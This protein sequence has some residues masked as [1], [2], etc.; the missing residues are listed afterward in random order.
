MD[1]IAETNRIKDRLRE[2][3][4]AEQIDDV[5]NQERSRVMEI[6]AAACDGPGLYQQ[7]LNLRNFRLRGFIELP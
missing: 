2:C 4:N 1:V 6:K 3:T 5:S 7:I